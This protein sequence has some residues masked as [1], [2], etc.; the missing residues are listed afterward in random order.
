[1]QNNLES[2]MPWGNNSAPMTYEIMSK[3]VLYSLLW[4]TVNADCF[5]LSNMTHGKTVRSEKFN[6][7]QTID[8]QGFRNSTKSVEI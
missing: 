5:L 3:P 4:N 6:I 1:M 2:E 8:F 7:K